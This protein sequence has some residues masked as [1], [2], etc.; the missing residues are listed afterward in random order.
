MN[1]TPT[2]GYCRAAPRSAPSRLVPSAV[3]HAPA[4]RNS[5]L[6]TAACATSCITPP[7][8]PPA[9][10]ASTMNPIWAQVE[11]AS[12]CLRSSWATAT[13]PSASAVTAPVQAATGPPQPEAASSGSVRSS[14]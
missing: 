5:R 2:T 13:S 10:A 8:T 14:R 3:S 6:L 7:A 4:A 1:A 9:P 11:A 12:S